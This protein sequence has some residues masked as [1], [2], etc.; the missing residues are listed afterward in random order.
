MAVKI[1]G[2]SIHEFFSIQ[3][4]FTAIPVGAAITQNQLDTLAQTLVIQAEV[5]DNLKNGLDSHNVKISLQ[6]NGSDLVPSA[7]WELFFHSAYMLFPSEFPKTLSTVLEK[8][9]VKVTMH[10]GD[11]YSL[12][13]A[14]GFKEIAQNETR[15]IYIV[16]AYWSV[17]ET[18][19]M[20]KWYLTSD[21]A[22]VEPRVIQSTDS[23]TLD[24]VAPFDEPRQWKRYRFDRYNP[25]TPQERY[26]RYYVRD[27]Q[28]AEQ[29]V[30]PT[31]MT[32]TVG[33]LTTTLTVDNTWQIFPSSMEA[34]KVA[35]YLK[36]KVIAII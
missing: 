27:T 35:Q 4:S 19:F 33:E 32:M 31:P 2:L 14:S 30:I 24:F 3:F 18:D 9:H 26:D 28:M 15:M 22:G 29:I 36:G 23:E 25:F 1:G 12:Q 17:S 5:T 8:E 6:N 10:G 13:P 16:V 7:G 21:E 20:P 11:L 34:A